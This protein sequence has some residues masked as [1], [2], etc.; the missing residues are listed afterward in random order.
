MAIKS[1]SI[2]GE[3][4]NVDNLAKLNDQ[5]VFV[6]TQTL[7]TN[8][9]NAMWRIRSDSLDLNTFLTDDNMTWGDGSTPTSP[10]WHEHGVVVYDK[11]LRPIGSFESGVRTDNWFYS[12]LRV[13]KHD[14]SYAQLYL[15][16]DENDNTYC[17]C[18]TPVSSASGDQIVTARWVRN[19]LSS[20]G[21]S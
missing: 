1:L 4:L 18:P 10:K 12:F 9:H 2:N 11:N 16:C 8:V 5:N 21:I 20:K 17:N 6:D 13:Y 14:R 19:L 3:F 7:S 15:V